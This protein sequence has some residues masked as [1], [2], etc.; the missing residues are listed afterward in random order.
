MHRGYASTSLLSE[1]SPA[2]TVVVEFDY[3]AGKL[4][5]ESV[6]EPESP[7]TLA[8]FRSRWL[9]SFATPCHARGATFSLGSVYGK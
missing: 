4:K 8:L 6:E 9:T 7:L 1:E 2:V 5:V 3:N